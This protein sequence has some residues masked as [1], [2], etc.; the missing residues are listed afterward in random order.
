MSRTRV[1]LLAKQF[2]N[3]VQQ[4]SFAEV[5]LGV[6]FRRWQCHNFEPIRTEFPNGCDE[7]INLN[8][9]LNI[10][11]ATQIV[12]SQNVRFLLT[13]RQNN[14]WNTRNVLVVLEFRQ[15]FAAVLSGHIQIE[16]NQLRSWRCCG[17]LELTP[18]EKVIEGLFTIVNDSQVDVQ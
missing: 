16:Q 3:A 11:I 2:I 9:F 18:A 17:I 13:R 12:A 7:L 10:G 1:D 15:Y 14:D 5:F 8:R 4:T 6:G